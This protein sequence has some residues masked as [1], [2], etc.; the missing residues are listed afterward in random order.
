MDRE[1]HAGGFGWLNATQFLGALNDNVFK[2]LVVFFLVSTFGDAGRS[3]IIAVASGLFVLPF[4]LF[5][6]AAGVLA[7]RLSKQ[8]L[9]LFFKAMEF[10]VMLM[11]FVAV[12]LRSEVLA[13][14]T[15]FAMGT[16]SAFFGPCKYGIVPELVPV[17]RLSWANSLL[18]M[19]T[20]LAIIIGT[21]L[22]SLLL[23][24]FFF[25]RRFDY[26][27]G[28][29][30][31]VAAAGFLLALRIPRT[32]PS[33]SSDR[34]SPLF[35]VE[36]A[37]TVRGVA[38]DRDLLM[39]ILGSAYF[40]FV[41]GFIQQ[42]V[43]LYGQDLL[44]LTWIRSGYLFPVA[45]LGI[46]L[47][48]AAA[49]RTSGRNIEFGIVPIGAALLT[50]GCIS[51]GAAPARFGPVLALFFVL[52]LGAGL[53]LV[54]LVAFIQY[55]APVEQR[56]RI[57]A[58]E[59]FLGFL[60]VA[61]SAGAF[62]LMTAVLGLSPAECFVVI[63]VLTGI[64]A[65]VAIL[66]LPD[67]LV[68][69]V[70]VLI[71]RLIYRVRVDGVESVPVD[72]GALL[73]P[74]HVTWVDSLLISATLQRRVRFVMSREV[75]RIRLLRPVF[76]LMGV[77]PISPGDSPKRIK[78]SLEV[79]RQA[80]CDGY[81][82]C[83]FAEGAITRNG[84]MLRF[85]SGWQHIVKGTN[86]PV[87]P[88]Y[89]GGAWGSIFSYYH[90]RLV[91][92]MPKRI[93][94]PVRLLY[95]APL[96]STSTTADLRQA[97]SLLSVR[98][99]D[100]KKDRR[101]V[102]GQT[103]VRTARR[104]WFREAL[105]D[106]SGKRFSHGRT[107]VAAAALSEK[108]REVVDD[109]VHVGIMLPASAGGALANVAVT[110]LGKVPVNLNFT[111]SP[112]AMASAVRQA[113]IRTMITSK[114]FLEKLK[115]LSPTE[116]TVYLEDLIK[117]ITPGMKARAMMKALFL[118]AGRWAP[119]GARPGPDDTATIIF[120]SGSTGA[121]KGVMLS[122]HNI[123]SNIEAFLMVCR[124]RRNDRMCAALPFFH[125]FGF[126]C[127]L[128]CPL[129][130]G[131]KVFF[132]P[133]P[134]DAAT[135]AECVRKERLTALLATPTF[136]VT[137]MRKA[138]R[139]DFA[140]LRLVVAGAEKLKR[141]VADAY[142]ERFG[143]RPFEGY[144][145][146]ELAPVVSLNVRD[147]T[148]DGVT[149]A[150][151]KEESAGHP[152]P[153]VAVRV[154]DPE[155]G[156]PLPQGNEGMLMVTG[157]NV[158]R[159]YLENPEATASAIRDGW[160]VTGDLARV[161]DDGFIFLL[162]RLSRFSKIGGEMVPHVGVEEKLLKALDAL[163]PVL[164]VTAIA[165]ERK[166]EQLA[167]L[168]TPEA[169]DVENLRRIVKESDLPNLWKPRPENLFPVESFPTLGSGKLDLRRLRALAETMA[170]GR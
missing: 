73:V 43:L 128:W 159:G 112:D 23:E 148:I 62:Y 146:T 156:A 155:S 106:S 118:P 104:F 67:F 51:L 92:A 98:Y 26:L 27:A 116:G 151:S 86:C 150:G 80:L 90:G 170:K 163:H 83:I 85:R 78:E 17:E 91:S 131:F 107:L 81:L 57:I 41:G 10:P 87:I 138:T 20:Y 49:G 101:R 164:F 160:Y 123:L 50:I 34:V 28:F 122:H 61:L 38:R 24:D 157:P 124:F 68:R 115:G 46:G 69:F 158:M 32:P 96:P 29:C 82:V 134:L 100:M 71:T 125:S 76:R 129:I 47:G 79:A 40:M 48:A 145:T 121:P 18:A 14:A 44:G 2:L 36:I 167:V 166:G 119:A 84:N 149:Q 117:G 59:S 33:G 70:V 144:G 42:N 53:Y 21:V 72:G 16:Q 77:I 31:A 56:G 5:S 133:N 22:P 13:Y 136:L 52:G 35:L 168:Y 12:L 7:D 152:I 113:R 126:T 58:A 139:E 88:L 93:P 89:I 95:G 39:A 109:D 102:L 25:S 169:G 103:F 127:T 97:V 55:K 6:N 142:E 65:C 165:D 60:G 11:G 4:L 114:A 37:R 94:Y 75:F 120:S 45:A 147:V 8:R 30:M 143:V 9:L 66:V 105:A 137:Y 15:V 99:F 108:I 64:L 1:K 110:L 3:R 74:N 162:G 140:S 135:I 130:S 19:A 161:D 141:S 132:H 63:G 154:V 153:G 111:V 54:P